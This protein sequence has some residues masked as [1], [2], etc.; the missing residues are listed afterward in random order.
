[1]SHSTACAGGSVVPG[2]A[3]PGTVRPRGFSPPRRVA[4]RF[5][6]RPRRPLPSLG[7][8]ADPRPSSDTEPPLDHVAVALLLRDPLPRGFRSPSSEEQEVRDTETPDRSR[9]VCPGLDVGRRPNRGPGAFPSEALHPVPLRQPTSPRSP[10]HASGRRPVSCETGLRPGV[11]GSVRHGTVG[12][13]RD[14]KLPWGFPAPTRRALAPPVR[15]S[16]R[17]RRVERSW[18]TEDP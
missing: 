14:P 2:V 12:S 8:H 15:S 10:S 6:S 13:A 5:A 17:R 16:A 4:P 3:S 18:R 1:M 11:P 7:S 9:P